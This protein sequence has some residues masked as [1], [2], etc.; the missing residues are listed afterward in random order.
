MLDWL[1]AALP[2]T[3]L[4]LLGLLPNAEHDVLPVNEM[5][6]G[7][8]D[9]KGVAFAACGQDIDPTDAGLLYDGTHPTLLAQHRLLECLAPMV[10]SVVFGEH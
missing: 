1:A 9:A 5:Y 8:S 10:E 4:L 7:L 6:R 3:R 2:S